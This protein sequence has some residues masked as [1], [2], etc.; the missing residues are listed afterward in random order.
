MDGNPAP[1]A[2][3]AV[4]ATAYRV[5]GNFVIESSHPCLPGHFPGEPVVPGVVILD[6]VLEGIGLP[7]EH[8]RRLSRVKFQR[9]LL[10]GQLAEIALASEPARL[11][12]RVSSQGQ[13]LV[14]GQ[15]LLA[16]PGAPAEE[17]R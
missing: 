5:I 9:P 15:V 16:W 14:T 4:G 13:T 6:H 3:V 11:N 12:F 1:E 10:P 17:A 7:P 2:P 8:E